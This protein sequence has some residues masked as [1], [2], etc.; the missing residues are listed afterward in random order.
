MFQD[1]QARNGG[2]IRL[3]FPLNNA[4]DEEDEVQGW[5]SRT[6]HGHYPTSLRHN[7][8]GKPSPVLGGS[9]MGI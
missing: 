7:R 4:L 3:F 5:A 8:A 1:A 2:E 9:K 6:W